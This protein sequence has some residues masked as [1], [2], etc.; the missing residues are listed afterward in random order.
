MDII[1]LNEELVPLYL[2]CLEDWSEE[3]KSAGDLH[4][5]WYHKMK[6]RGLRVKLARDDKGEVGGMIQ[7][8]PIE[9]THVLGK[10]LYFAYCIWVHGYDEGRGNFQKKGMGKRGIEVWVI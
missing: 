5:K 9:E 3:A 7:Y 2:I 1:D 8:A 10:D 6:E 4:E